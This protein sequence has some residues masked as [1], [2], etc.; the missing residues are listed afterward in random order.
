ML[1]FVVYSSYRCSTQNTHKAGKHV[2][3]E[4]APQ[5]LG[6]MDAFTGKS[7]TMLVPQKKKNH[8]SSTTRVAVLLLLLLNSRKSNQCTPVRAESW[9]CCS[10]WRTR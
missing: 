5:R 9:P 2:T 8:A 1:I 6:P 10:R 3:T 7:R 4:H